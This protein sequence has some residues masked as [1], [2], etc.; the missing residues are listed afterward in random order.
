ML[1]EAARYRADLFY[2]PY[3]IFYFTTLIFT[4]AVFLIFP[5]ITVAVIVAVPSFTG[6]TTPFAS[7]VA[8]FVEED[9]QVIESAF[10]VAAYFS[11]AC[12]AASTF[13][14]ASI[15]SPLFLFM[16]SLNRQCGHTI[17]DEITIWQT[18]V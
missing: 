3:S 1:K 6:V 16:L 9:F 14:S 10:A 17:E 5:R 7:T 11:A 15:A 8:Y 12:L 2:L 4:L 13:L 18:V